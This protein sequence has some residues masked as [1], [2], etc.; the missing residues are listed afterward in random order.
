MSC[1]SILSVFL[2]IVLKREIKFSKR[3]NNKCLNKICFI[4]QNYIYNHIYQKNLEI[5]AYFY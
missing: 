3:N 4:I 5:F 2:I 1:F